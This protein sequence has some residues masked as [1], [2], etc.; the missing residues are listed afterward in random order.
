MSV[1]MIGVDPHKASHTA[2][3]VDDHENVLGRLRVQASG[4][5]AEQLRA[6]G[7]TW[8]DHAWA[9][10]GAAGLGLLL[11]Q[12]LVAA[13]ENVV[14]V[15]PKL[16]ARVR[17]LNTGQV[18]KND[19]NDARSVA[20]AALRG[21]EL[22]LVHSE[23]QAA[24]MR[25]WVRR[26]RDI[27]RTRN[28]VAN[29]LHTLL[30]ELVPG[31]FAGEISAPQAIAVLNTIHPELAADTARHELAADLVEDLQRLDRQLKDVRARLL[32][33]VA[34]AQTSTTDIFGVGPIIAATV[35]GATG[36]VDRFP[37]ADRFAAYTGTAPIEASSG[38]RKIYRLSQRGNRQ[39][40]HAIHMAAVTQ[41]RNRH[42][43]GRTYYDRK[44]N[45][46]MSPKMALRALKRRVSDALYK[47]MIND[48]RRARAT[49]MNRNPGGQPGSDS[50]SSA[51]GSHPERQLF[52]QATPG[53]PTSLEPSRLTRSRRPRGLNRQ[54]PAN[55]T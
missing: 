21:H 33:I 49:E 4:R 7:A 17:L 53:S 31:G 38:P 55:C 27:A 42:S 12:Q 44:I 23:G 45:E 25:V 52:G 47:A 29:R 28:R 20:V 30:C 11:A 16:A 15:Q 50:V 43:V 8:P 37:T 39:L 46:G 19:P 24:V 13:G 51:A 26:R 5:Q 2:V 14:D 54:A 6:W 36:N 48:A 40:N 22:P 9:I 1:V 10:E 3:A 34:A 35:I 41:I 18:N 32:S